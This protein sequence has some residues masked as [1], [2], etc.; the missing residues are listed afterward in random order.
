MYVSLQ[1]LAAS[2]ADADEE[3]V[4]GEIS[5]SSSQVYSCV[6]GGLG[7]FGLQIH[8]YMTGEGRATAR[9][10]HGSDGSLV[11]GAF[12]MIREWRSTV[13]LF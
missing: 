5:R 9:F 7:L 6:P 1:V 12:W 4:G 11:T 8:L 10:L 13:R 2:D 3:R